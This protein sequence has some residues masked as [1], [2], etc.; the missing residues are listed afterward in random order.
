MKTI[1]AYKLSDGSIVECEK[2]AIETE[3]VLTFKNEMIELVE[4]SDVYVRFNDVE[5][6]VEFMEENA[7]KLMKIFSKRFGSSEKLTI[8]TSSNEPTKTKSIL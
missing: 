5:E 6:F 7:E 8:F 2:E 1:T 3:K 4:D